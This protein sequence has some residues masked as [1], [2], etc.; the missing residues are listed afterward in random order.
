MFLGEELELCALGL[1]KADARE[2]ELSRVVWGTPRRGMRLIMGQ[3]Q[4][5]YTKFKLTVIGEK[6][7]LHITTGQKTDPLRE[8]ALWRR[9]QEL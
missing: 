4:Q 8:R 1:H 9:L 3:E 7:T 5:D 2:R 6:H